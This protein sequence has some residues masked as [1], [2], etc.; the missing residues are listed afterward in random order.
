MRPLSTRI[1]WTFCGPSPGV[2]PVHIDV[3]GFIR[4]P[5][6]DRGSSCRNTSRSRTRG[7]TFSIPITVIRVSGRVRHIRPLP[8]DS[9]TA[10]V[11]VS[12]T[13]KLAPLIATLAERN[14]RRRCRRA[15]PAS[16]AGSSVSPGSTSAISRRKMSR[17]S[18]RLRWMAGTRMCDGRS[19]PSCTISSARSVSH[20]GDPGG[21]ER[22]VE[23]DLL[24][25]HRLDLDHLVGPGGPD[26]VDG[27]PV[28]LGGVAGPV[29]DAAARRSPP[30]RAAPDRCRDGPSCAP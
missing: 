22:L 11:P 4:S 30:P 10:S 18:A 20:G 5:V 1:R 17:I 15:A 27:D 16:T 28:G 7:T 2:T 25:G 6:D 8:S 23:P 24:G 21:L 12:A 19:C 9:T 14:F 13:A 29:H 3:Y 26:Q